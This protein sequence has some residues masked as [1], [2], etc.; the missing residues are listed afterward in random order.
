MLFKFHTDNQQKR[1]KK[2]FHILFYRSHF[3]TFFIIPVFHDALISTTPMYEPGKLSSM[4][5]AFSN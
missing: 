3:S 5:F 4:N 2:F 1:Y